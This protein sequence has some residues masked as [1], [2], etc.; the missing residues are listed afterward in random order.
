MEQND[1]ELLQTVP[2]YH[3]Q[4]VVKARRVPV[5]ASLFGVST[6]SVDPTAPASTPVILEIANYLLDATSIGDVLQDLNELEIALLRE[7]ASCGGR[8]NSRD[9]ALYFQSAG[10]LGADKQVDT[11]TGTPLDPA[12]SY[13]P[14]TALQPPHYPAPHPHGLFEQA[15]RH[16][17]LLGLVF[18]GKQ[19]NFVGR[20]YS[21]G[22][23]DGVLIVSQMVLSV[24]RRKWRVETGANQPAMSAPLDERFQ[25]FQRTLYLYWSF[26]AGTHGGLTLIN[27]GLLSRTSLR[28]VVEYMH[29]QDEVEQ[30]RLENDHP[31]L[32]FVRFLLMH[33]NLL[34]IRQNLLVAEPAES[35]FSLPLMERV[36]RCYR[37]YV[38]GHFWNELLYLTEINIRPLPDPLTPATSEVLHARQ[39]VLERLVQ[40]T[41]AECHE[42]TAFVAR[43]KLHVPYLL[44]PR[45]FGPRAERYSQGCNPYGWD[46]RLRRGWLTHREGWHMVEG[47]FIRALLT[48]PLN[49]MGLIEPLPEKVSST[50]Q[51]SPDAWRI[52]RDIPL[53]APVDVPVQVDRLIVQ[54]NFDIVV[55]APVAE[56]LLVR[57]D[58]FAERVSLELIAQYR[59]S[60]ASVTRAIQR[61]FHV[62]TMLAVLEGAAGG[63]IPQNVRYSL[64]E[65]ERQARRV[66]IW[67]NVTL[68]E[69]EEPAFLDMLFAD[70]EM[71]T[72]F[73]RRITPVFAEVI[74]AHLSEVEQW[75]GQQQYLPAVSETLEETLTAPYSSLAQEAQWHL[76][77]DGVLRPLYAVLDF[78]RLIEAVLLC[79]RDPT[80]GWLRITAQSLQ[81]ALDKDVTLEQIIRFLQSSCDEGIPGS[82]LIR[83]KLWGGGYT[84]TQPLQV[85]RAPLLRLPEE[86]LSD[87]QA[88]PALAAL[89][90]SAI[91]EGPRLVHVASENLSHVLDLLQQRG[92]LIED[93]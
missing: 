31:R 46:F 22:M 81:Q 86:V 71:Q 51:F 5:A 76:Q 44:F 56:G 60:K 92:F 72:F 45:Q 91:P 28:Q 37:I 2:L 74:T 38:D 25:R 6:S 84:H 80:T 12:Q 11:V 21:S 47:G 55:L 57:L 62:D 34:S 78:F 8:A 64:A 70:P 29:A 7:L 27:N 87:L 20:E 4:V 26:V 23:H 77:E 83:L 32:L 85:E 13:Q 53:D 63:D 89:L 24:I 33:L 90:G 18:W 39:Q 1:L 3:L 66:E 16:L 14:G 75:L 73:R 49:W 30:L 43:T 59:L 50:F 19:T 40:E 79:E 93:P 48:G 35:F 15:L 68:L 36:H 61:G 82:L 17:L 69:V 58:R 88:D 65:W 10:L 9:L 41:P 52:L 42:Q 54:P 67:S